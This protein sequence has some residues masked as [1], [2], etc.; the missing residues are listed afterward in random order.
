MRSVE[1]VNVQQVA[2]G[3][4]DIEGVG[5]RPDAA[6]IARMLRVPDHE[7]DARMRFRVRVFLGPDGGIVKP[8]VTEVVAVVRW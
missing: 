1:I 2:H 8:V 4:V 6:A 3:G 7:R 5:Q